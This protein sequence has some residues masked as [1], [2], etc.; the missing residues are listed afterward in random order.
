MSRDELLRKIS[1]YGFA[2]WE[3]H[4]YL[5]T[6][7]S[8]VAAI[9]RLKAYQQKASEYKKQYVSKYGPLTVANG[10]GETWLNDPWP[11]ERRAN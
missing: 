7:P 2:V 1:E 8:D 11:W 3:L 9:M 10:S 4:L 5:D 6:H